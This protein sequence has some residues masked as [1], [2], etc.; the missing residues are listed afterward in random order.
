M[1]KDFKLLPPAAADYFT[2]AIS[3]ALVFDFGFL[4][5]LGWQPNYGHV[6][7]LLGVY[8]PFFGGVFLF[9]LLLHK[10]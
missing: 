7:A 3:F 1:V 5:Q 9:V 6:P 4:P 10:K 8:G 2:Y